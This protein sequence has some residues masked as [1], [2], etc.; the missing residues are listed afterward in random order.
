M[1]RSEGGCRHV[2]L[3]HIFISSSYLHGSGVSRRVGA[4]LEESR[5]LGRRLPPLSGRAA[6]VHH[7][8][9]A[10][11]QT[12]QVGR[13][14]ALHHPHLAHTHTTGEMRWFCLR[15]HIGRIPGCMTR[16]RPQ[17]GSAGLGET[18]TLLLNSWAACVTWDS[19]WWS[20][21]LHLFIA[22]KLYCCFVIFQKAKHDFNNLFRLLLRCFLQNKRPFLWVCL[23]F[24]GRPPAW[25]LLLL[26]GCCLI[27]I[28]HFLCRLLCSMD[29]FILSILAE[30]FFIVFSLWASVSHV[31]LVLDYLR[32]SWMRT[33]TTL[34][35]NCLCTHWKISIFYKQCVCNVMFLGLFCDICVLMC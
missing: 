32:V 12:H 14:F 29:V 5:L 2:S 20:A 28:F 7:H 3:R 26:F 16:I 21:G 15:R 34:T 4:H 18:P 24:A 11:E 25:C 30:F 19:V 33:L 17:G 22:Q 27:S 10:S 23:D 31:L 13:L 1:L 9:P 8:G 35:M 6:L